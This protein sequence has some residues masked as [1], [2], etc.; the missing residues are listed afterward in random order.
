M[1]SK[2]EDLK[3]YLSPNVENLIH[4][5]IDLDITNLTLSDVM[6]NINHTYPKSTIEREHISEGRT[7]LAVLCKSEYLFPLK[8][9]LLIV[10]GDN[11]DVNIMSQKYAVVCV[12][13]HDISSETKI[14]NINDN[15]CVYLAKNYRESMEDFDT[16]YNR[17]LYN[18]YEAEVN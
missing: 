10:I 14:M 8:G 4:T 11:V 15:I 3:E 2:M 1:M 5:Q 18:A 17:F 7:A 16:F 12:N 13:E 6:R 9:I